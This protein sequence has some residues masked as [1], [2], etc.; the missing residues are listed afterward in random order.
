MAL[1]M[2][3][4]QMPFARE[5]QAAFGPR[6]DLGSLVGHTGDEA[7]STAD[8]LGA[9][10]FA[11]GTD[12]VFGNAPDLWTAA[13]EATHV[14][15]QNAGV[16]P[17][18]GIGAAGDEHEQRADAVADLVVSGGSAQALLADY[19][20]LTGIAQAAPSSIVQLDRKDAQSAGPATAPSKASDA[21]AFTFIAKGEDAIQHMS[22]GAEFADVLYEV[23]VDQA[24]MKATHEQTDA[25]YKDATKLR[26]K[27]LEVSTFE[28]IVDG[29]T[30]VV[31]FASSL[32]G[33]ISAARTLHGA[34]ALRSLDK[35]TI[36]GKSE[37]GDGLRAAKLRSSQ[38]GK[39]TLK[40][41]GDLVNEGVDVG[42]GVVKG[43]EKTTGGV[44]D[45]D[46]KV[47]AD[48]ILPD[49][50]AA[51]IEAGNAAL[52]KW[53]QTGSKLNFVSLHQH[54]EKGA[55][56]FQQMVEGIALVAKEGTPL[57]ENSYERF[58]TVIDGFEKARARY[59]SSVQRVSSLLNAYTAGGAAGIANPERGVYETI[60]EWKA[61][62]DPRATALHFA[63]DQDSKAIHFND[64]HI[65]VDVG[66]GGGRTTNY[67]CHRYHEITL[68]SEDATLY[69]SD[70]AAGSELMKQGL[71]VVGTR[72][73]VGEAEK[74]EDKAGGLKLKISA[75]IAKAI[76]S[77]G[78]PGTSNQAR[79]Q[80]ITPQGFSSVSSRHR[81]PWFDDWR[82]TPEFA[83]FWKATLGGQY[84]YLMSPDG[85][86]QTIPAAV[87]D[88]AVMDRS[89]VSSA[90][91]G[92]GM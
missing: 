32:S 17:I 78:I 25:A 8:A 11:S 21:D 64:V 6:H 27:M 87:N 73:P 85:K 44:D 42:K 43:I 28:K 49:A 54:G 20:P 63:L 7:T 88:K 50:N 29:V 23:V 41:V 38:R 9:N 3:A 72:G 45:P 57:T 40:A 30:A 67:F 58:K 66:T 10:A 83:E 19:A 60:Q 46:Q 79:V 37:P 82:S 61:T 74:R 91:H 68:Q 55:L 71:T 39:S 26:E 15:Q 51:A 70:G 80:F 92:G 89:A 33:I 59:V 22:H 1:K 86:R 56:A 47:D 52:M 16:S 77:L 31:D 76:E 5:L 2:V 35:K 36:A 34:V 69:V 65:D 90:V 48:T 24:G 81:G 18:D 12:V 4:S 75:S 14:V 84:A 62:N 13:H 53:A